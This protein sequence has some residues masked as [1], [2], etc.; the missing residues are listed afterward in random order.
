MTGLHCEL[1][2]KQF[3]ALCDDKYSSVLFRQVIIQEILPLDLFQF[4]Y[5]A[6]LNIAQLVSS[7]SGIA[8]SSTTVKPKCS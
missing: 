1:A 5:W 3:W 6:F 8:D 2:L 4:D 7:V